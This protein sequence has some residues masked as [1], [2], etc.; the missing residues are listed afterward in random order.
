MGKE[1]ILRKPEDFAAVLRAKSVVR[2]TCVDLYTR[3]N[4][5]AYP[6]LGLVVSRRL[7]PL[8]TRRNRYKRLMRE[9]FRLK[10]HELGSVDVVARLKSVCPFDQFRHEFTWLLGHCQVSMAMATSTPTS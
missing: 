10:Q 7:V 9:T 8:A 5:L 3:P 4:G 6:R 2:G 1:K